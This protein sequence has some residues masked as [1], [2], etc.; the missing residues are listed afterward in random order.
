MMA[1]VLEQRL[2]LSPEVLQHLDL[3]LGCRACENACPSKV[4]YGWLADGMRAW[5]EPRRERPAGQ[6]KWRRTLF[7][8]LRLPRLLRSVGRMLRAY[9][10]FGLQ[11]LARKSGLL[12]AFGLERTEALLP[13][14]QK[15]RPLH[16]IHAAVGTPRGTVGLFLGCVAQVMDAPTLGA[17]IFILT[18]L[19]YTVHVPPS[20]NCCGALH[21]HNG[22]ADVALTLAQENRSAFNVSGLQAILHAAS[23]CGASLAEYDPPLAA[24][25][26][27]ISAF[28]N[29][30]AGWDRIELLPFPHS[31]A[32]HEACASRNVLHDQDAA[33]RLLQ[34]IPDA[35]IMALAGNDQCCGAAGSY[36][37]TQ[38]VMAGLLLRDKIEATKLGGALTIVTSNPGC[39]MHLAAGL[40][41][42]GLEIEILHP[43]GLVAR[44]MGYEHD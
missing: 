42:E 14:L 21:G 26:L 39:A 8:L 24:P 44:Q 34:R 29:Q 27:D 30:A 7:G 18:R 11:V 3:C 10:Q 32:V 31:V 4:R 38:P 17:T 43:A 37:L 19:G 25:L 1:A 20:Q 12:A 40:R 33:Y 23:G 35:K 36:A 15:S 28:L 2:P 41:A 6:I 13:A 16:G 5:M 9:Q 22:E